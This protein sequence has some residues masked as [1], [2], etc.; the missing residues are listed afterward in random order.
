[1]ISPLYGTPA[2][3][4]GIIPGDRI[5]EIEGESTEGITIDKA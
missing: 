4:A 2:Y 5:V 1:V 3:R